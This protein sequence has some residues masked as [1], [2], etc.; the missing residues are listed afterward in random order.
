MMTLLDRSPVLP[1]AGGRVVQIDAECRT[2]NCMG[3]Q[4]ACIAWADTVGLGVPWS[5]GV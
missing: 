4:A 2:T 5:L 3:V 1:W